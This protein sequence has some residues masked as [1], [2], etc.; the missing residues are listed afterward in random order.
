MS[1]R[2]TTE[3]LPENLLEHRA[4]MAWRQ[5]S[6]EWPLPVSVS[7]ESPLLTFRP[8]RYLSHLVSSLGVY[9]AWLHEALR[10]AGWT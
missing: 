8:Y 5:L 10:T 4:V 6:P 1:K 2:I 3:I 9:Q 7:W